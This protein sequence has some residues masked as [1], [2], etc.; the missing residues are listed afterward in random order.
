VNYYSDG[1]NVYHLEAV[2]LFNEDDRR[3]CT[4]CG[5]VWHTNTSRAIPKVTNLVCPTCIGEL[6]YLAIP[7]TT[8][9]TA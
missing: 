3:T 6:P 8:E 9:R 4:D 1:V 2:I 5:E 7:D